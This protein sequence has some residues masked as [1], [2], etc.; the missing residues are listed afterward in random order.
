MCKPAL[1]RCLVQKKGKFK[2][3]TYKLLKKGREI[4]KGMGLGNKISAGKARILH[5]PQEA[6]KLQK[7]EILVT[8]KT[9]PDWDPILKKAGGIITNQGGRTSHAAIVA[10]EMGAAAIVGTGNAVE[11]IQEGQE[12]TISCA[13]GGTGM[14]YEGFLNWE[15]KEVNIEALKKTQN[16]THAYSG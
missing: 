6:S 1:K 15:E 9:D 10:R 12:I 2:I 13:E 3:H 11:V 14:V 16:T 5:N 8:E 7:G 4:T